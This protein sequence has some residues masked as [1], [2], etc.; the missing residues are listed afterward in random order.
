ME[1]EAI[2]ASKGPIGS[3]LQQ[4]RADG[5]N[6]SNNPKLYPFIASSIEMQNVLKLAQKVAQVSATVLLIGESGVGKE[7]VAKAIHQL[8]PRSDKPFIKVNCGA[9]PVNLLES[10]LFGYKRGAFTGADPKGKPGFFTQANSGV[11]LLD[12]IAE[13]PLNLQVKL[14]RVLQERKVTP[15]GGVEPETIDIQVV[16]ATNADLDKMVNEGAFREDLYYRLNVVPIH[17]P[18]LRERIEDIANLANYFLDKYNLNYKR[19]VSFSS[20]AIDF[21]KSYPWYGNV[22]ELENVIERIAITSEHEQIDYKLVSKY[23]HWKKTSGKTK[24][25]VTNIIPLQEAL[26][27]VEE[28]LI[29]M[30]ME[31]YKSA[32]LAAQALGISQPTMSRKYQAIRQRL[33][34]DQSELSPRNEMD[35]LERELD[36]QLQS[37]AIVTAASLNVDEIKELL[38]NINEENPIYHKLQ[39]RLTMIR[40]DEGKI[41]WNYIWRVTEDHRVISL[42]TD[43]KL[44]IRPGEEYVGPPVMMETIFAAMEG[45]VGVTPKYSDKFGEWKSSLAPIRDEM[46]QVIAIIGSDYSVDYIDREILKLS[47]MLNI[48]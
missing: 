43:K 3:G 35:I 33:K 40:D 11:L 44:K 18:P 12:E 32:K 8:G 10:E 38:Q 23:I 46:E 22:R 34:S 9:I 17:I 25:L 42:V 47:K 26:D 41:E 16:A 4:Q 29:L 24:P 15:V 5:K 7:M 14:L 21:L 1:S 6:L 19:Q 37:I 31:K 27:C 13:L 45:V 39:K 48:S 2:S 36:K 30:A 28:Q 20:D